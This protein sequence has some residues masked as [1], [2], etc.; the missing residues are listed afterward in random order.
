[1][2]RIL[3]MKSSDNNFPKHISNQIYKKLE[4]PFELD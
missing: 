1:M 4:K 3:D 2:D